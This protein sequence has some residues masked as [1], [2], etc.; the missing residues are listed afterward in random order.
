MAYDWRP[1]G[2]RAA[3]TTAPRVVVPPRPSPTRAPPTSGPPEEPRVS[4]VIDE[5]IEAAEDGRVGTRSGRS[6]RPSALR[7]LRG[8]LRYHV[9]RDLGHMQ[10]RDV[11]RRHVQALVD[12]LAGEGLSESRIRSVISAVRALYG[13]AIDRGYVELS[14][15]SGLV[16]PSAEAWFEDGEPGSEVD[17]DPTDFT[18]VDSVADEWEERPSA[19]RRLRGR[20]HNGARRERRPA[21][22][23]SDYKPIALLP[24]RILSLV[25]RIVL[26][27]F[28]LF[29]LFT[30]AGSAGG[31]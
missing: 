4:T 25:L 22:S 7:D 13:Y 8:I 28:I 11:R 16:I 5:F 24:E 27:I 15:A 14:P 30:I 20:R 6:Y 2:T 10:L 9:S 3:T 19:T 17:D 12:R 1:T 31:A 23:G 26:V 29:A 18:W 21:R